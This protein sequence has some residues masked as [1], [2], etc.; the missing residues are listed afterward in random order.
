MRFISTLLLSVMLLFSSLS[1]AQEIATENSEVIKY[2]SYRQV[3]GNKL[4]V[5]DTLIIQ[6][7]N[8]DGE[9]A[10]D[11][12]LV[13]SKGEKPSIELAWIEDMQ[14]NIIRRLKNNEIK[15]RNYI[16]DATL[17][18][19]DFLRSFQLKHNQY[20]YRIVFSYKTTM[21]KFFQIASIDY[22]HRGKPV[23]DG[24]LVVEIP[25]SE[26]IKFQQRNI[27]KPL[28]QQSNE[29]STY[30]WNFSYTPRPYQLNAP[31]TDDEAPFLQIL[32]IDFRYGIP[33]STQDWKAFGNWI[34]RLNQGKDKLPESEKNKIDGLLTGISDK[35]EKCRTLFHYMQD[36]NR[37][38]NVSIDIGGLQTYPAEYVCNNRYGDCKALTN[39]MKAILKYAG[40][41]SYYTLIN[42]N[43][44]VK[45]IDPGF[46][47]QAFNHVIL[48]VPF[49][50]DT[51]YLECTSKNLPFG[52]IYTSIQDRKALLIDEENSHLISIPA[53]SWQD[54]ACSRKH[55]IHLLS[56]GM[57]QVGMSIIQRGSKF[58]SATYLNTSDKKDAIEKY[59]IRNSPVNISKFEESTLDKQPRDSTSIRITAKYHFPASSKIYGNNLV[60]TP[61]GRKISSYEAPEKR[62]QQVRLDYPEYYADTSIY[63]IPEKKISKI[64]E[65]IS[66]TTPFGTYTQDYRQEGQKLYVY[67]T[68]HI[69]AGKYDL[70]RYEAFYKFIQAVRNNE[71]K[72]IYLEIL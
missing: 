36:Y 24:R 55:E 21:S 69:F 32:P 38:I 51:L 12:D 42:M 20:P 14:G 63:I 8:R 11:V 59:I 17:Y 49:E 30:T 72:K 56:G 13:Y 9:S 58:E 60:I 1:I 29:T 4:I 57:D 64:P 18:Q 54:V 7:N 16:S 37:Y 39:Y 65:N 61:F 25:A 67:K 27:G 44:E 28:I 19:D 50:Q 43:E 22:S 26:K 46:A 15:D 10:A 35:K 40:I 70:D 5:T 33:G 66:L 2:S 23:H 62:E 41:D 52:Y 53:L 6:I 68:I 47:S 3:R 48:T 31:Y 71:N 34:F 45:D